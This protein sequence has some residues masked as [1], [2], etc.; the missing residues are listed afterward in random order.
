MANVTLRDPKTQE[1][2]ST[3]HPEHYPESFEVLG[4]VDEPKDG[5]VWLDGKWRKQGD[6]ETKIRDRDMNLLPA[7]V[8]SLLVHQEARIHMLEQA[9]SELFPNQ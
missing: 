8:R 3:A 1:V 9:V 5:E 2:I 6:Y 4:Q 7:A